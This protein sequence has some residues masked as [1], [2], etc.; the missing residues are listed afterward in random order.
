MGDKRRSWAGVLFGAIDDATCGRWFKDAKDKSPWQGLPNVP[1]KVAWFVSEE[2]ADVPYCYSGCEYPA[3][4]FPP[5]MEEIR[6]EVCHR[7]GIP[8]DE[9]PNSCNVNIY[10]DHRGEIV[11]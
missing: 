4:V 8:P 2:F 7:C 3:T 5:W 11:R 10:E 9:Y 6:R 1:R